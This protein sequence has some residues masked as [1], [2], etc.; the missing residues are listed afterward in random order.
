MHI[1]AHAHTCSTQVQLLRAPE[2]HLLLVSVITFPVLHLLLLVGDLK[3]FW[4]ERRVRWRFLPIGAL[5]YSLRLLGGAWSV[6]GDFRR[7]LKAHVPGCSGW[8]RR[9]QGLLRWE[10]VAVPASHPCVLCSWLS[11]CT[12]T[13]APCRA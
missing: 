9:G 1:Y 3:V 7:D 13:S 5:K 6:L 2:T 10:T 8:V 4:G 11:S 12:T